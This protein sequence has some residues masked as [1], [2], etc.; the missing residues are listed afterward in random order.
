MSAGM[1]GANT[2][3]LRGVSDDFDVGIDQ[4]ESSALIVR[5]AVDGVVWVGRD[6]EAFVERTFNVFS[7]QCEA[8]AERIA[9]LAS[10]LERQAA[11]QDAA[12]AASGMPGITREAE[13]AQ[14]AWL[15]SAIGRDAGANPDGAAS[16]W[17]AV[18]DLIMPDRGT[19]EQRPRMGPL[20]V[21]ERPS[22]EDIA[23]DY[24]VVEDIMV[25]DPT[26]N[27]DGPLPLSEYLELGLLYVQG[28]SLIHI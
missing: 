4:I 7:T 15:T 27:L 3:E 17:N 13:T 11:E 23:Q 14:A 22:I 12:S 9:G 16:I 5:Q 28:L 8:L 6:A 26:G 18:K 24:Q 1:L 10:D 21:E 25:N 20:P 19:S 2:E